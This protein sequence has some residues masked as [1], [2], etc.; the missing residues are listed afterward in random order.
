M[1]SCLSMSS[2]TQDHNNNNDQDKDKDD[3]HEDDYDAH[4]DN[5]YQEV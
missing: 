2:L 3:Y 1:D 4:K 5:E